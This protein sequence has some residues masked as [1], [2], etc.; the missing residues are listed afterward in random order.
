M[1]TVM[2]LAVPGM[3]VCVENHRFN[4]EDVK[5]PSKKIT[6]IDDVYLEQ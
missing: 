4:A 3:L 2:I 6:G 1:K 5:K